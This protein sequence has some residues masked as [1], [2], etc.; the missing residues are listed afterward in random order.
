ME[1]HLSVIFVLDVA[2]YSRQMNTDE[3][4]T[5]EAFMRLRKNS[6]EPR[7]AEHNGHIVKFTGDGVISYFSSTVDATQCA[8]DIQSDA[9]A[10]N[11]RGAQSQRLQLRIGIH[12]GE[13]IFEEDKDIYGD[14]VNIATRL[15]Q[16]AW[17][18]CIFLSKV[19]RDQVIK[20]TNIELIRVGKE[21][22]K[23]IADPVEVYAIDV[24]G[25]ETKK[26]ARL[27]KRHAFST[28]TAAIVVVG[29]IVASTYYMS[30]ERVDPPAVADVEEAAK[31]T[32]AILPFRTSSENGDNVH[33]ADGIT[34]DIIANLSKV[35]AVN[36]ISKNSSSKLAFTETAHQFVLEELGAR[37]V[38]AG[39]VQQ[40]NSDDHILVDAKLVDAKSGDNLW[41]EQY[42]IALSGVF[43]LPHTMVDKVVEL[44]AVRV[45][46]AEQSRILE[47]DTSSISAYTGFNKAW[48]LY[49][50][51]TPQDLAVALLE[52]QKVIEI[53]P[54]YA[55]AYAAIGHVYL[56]SWLWGWESYAGT[57]FYSAPELAKEYLDKSVSVKPSAVAHQLSANIALYDR[58]FDEARGEATQAVNLEPS[59]TNGLLTLAE[60]L[61]YMG[62]QNDALP[63][64]EKV[65]RLDPLNPAYASFLMGLIHFG[66]EEYAIAAQYLEAALEY[67]PKDF[68]PAAPLAAAYAILDD[69][70]NM[71]RAFKRYLDGWPGANIRYFR[72]YWPYQHQIDENRLL[73]GLRLAGMPEG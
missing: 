15:E 28:S 10:D 25:E 70:E 46:E 9:M 13:V 37:Y 30:S 36:V 72:L 5:H 19:V 71:Q 8:I 18:G 11:F 63:L 26:R 41:A 67:N 59:D 31:P 39:G 73:D 58:R 1:T 64:V 29:L 16:I 47:K 54:K 12:M 50:K 61:I 3:M 21:S 48:K 56:K 7:T 45:S 43:E 23:N 32:V 62:L 20:K 38:L 42:D 2:G 22:V 65:A 4:G 51:N 69:Q 49:Q 60:I 33:L 6:I 57:D 17:P 53:D 40:Q 44:L 68:A 24:T 14:D 52:L 34:E 27:G 35:S 55:K 66:Q